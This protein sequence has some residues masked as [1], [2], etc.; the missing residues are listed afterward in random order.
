MMEKLAELGWPPRPHVMRYDRSA[1]SWAVG[2]AVIASYRVRLGETCGIFRFGGKFSGR[3]ASP[4]QAAGRRVQYAT[5]FSK[6]DAPVSK[7]D[8]PDLGIAVC[9]LCPLA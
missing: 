7:I 8:A 2:A 4:R 5:Q 9:P 3:M 6:I 1:I